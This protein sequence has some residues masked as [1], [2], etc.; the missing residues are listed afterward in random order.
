MPLRRSLAALTLAGFALS[1]FAQEPPA[2]PRIGLVLGGGGARGGA[3]LGVLQVLEDL[4]VPVDC[5]AGTSMGALA[6]GAYA[7]GVAPADIAE[8][9]RE[10]DWIHIFDDTAG[11]E[12]ENMRQKSLDDRYY[13]GLELG[14]SAKGLRFREGALAGEKLKLFFNQ[15]VRSE[16]G[17][18]SIEDLALP[19]SII[20]TDIGTGERVAMREGN[21]TSAMR[22]SMS[23]P[24]LMSPV[25]RDDRKLVDGGLTDNLPV[26]R[27][28][29]RGCDEVIAVVT[30][31]D[32]T[33]LKRPGRR[34]W[35]PQARGARVHVVHPR[36]ALEIGSWDLDGAR[37]ERA[38]D[39]GYASGRAF[40]GA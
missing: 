32:G 24:G 12:A 25:L 8:E 22:A 36:R 27:L 14:V 5:I 30:Q 16:L 6:G 31:P 33:A 1:C 37:M 17:D 21:L 39:A 29:E 7:A 19:L 28:A 13:S 3:H 9:I 15:L 40:L 38:I 18:R 35:R 23:V 34:G 11:R 2:R 26:E 20:A 4:H 10:T